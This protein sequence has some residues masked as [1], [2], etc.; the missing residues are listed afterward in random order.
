[1]RDEVRKVRE[2]EEKQAL[3][4]IREGYTYARRGTMARMDQYTQQTGKLHKICSDD[5][6]KE[7][8]EDEKR[9]E[10]EGETTKNSHPHKKSWHGRFRKFFAGYVS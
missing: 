5:K 2:E 6:V 1:M 4:H 8:A 10:T 3:S 7:I 9:E